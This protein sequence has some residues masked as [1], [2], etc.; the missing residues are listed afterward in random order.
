MAPFIS[1]MPVLTMWASLNC[2]RPAYAL[3]RAL[4][5]YKLITWIYVLI[6]MNNIRPKVRNFPT[7]TMEEF[8][9]V[10]SF[11]ILF[12]IGILGWHAKANSIK[13]RLRD[14]FRSIAQYPVPETSDPRLK[15]WKIRE[16]FPGDL[17]WKDI[18]LGPRWMSLIRRAAR[19]K[20]RWSRR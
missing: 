14:E 18:V 4:G 3:W 11:A 19:I 12:S 1:L 6:I 8:V 5:D 7:G 9:F 17:E 15:R 13:Y 10:A 20:A 16:R 2:G